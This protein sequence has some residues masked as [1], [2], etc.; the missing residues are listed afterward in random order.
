MTPV[1]KQFHRDGLAILDSTSVRETITSVCTP[2][3]QK[4]VARQHWLKDV[5]KC[6]NTPKSRSVAQNMNEQ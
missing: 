5:R 4:P 3:V 1:L 6:I 2:A